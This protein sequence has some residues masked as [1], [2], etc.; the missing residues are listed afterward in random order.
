MSTGKLSFGVSTNNGWILTIE[1]DGKSVIIDLDDS[2]LATLTLSATHALMAKA[3]R[4]KI[5]QQ[6]K[7]FPIEIK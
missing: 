6:I 5:P 2:Q 7:E 3:K 1:G 4:A